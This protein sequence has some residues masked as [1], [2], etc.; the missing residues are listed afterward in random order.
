MNADDNHSSDSA[1]PF[2]RH[3][4]STWWKTADSKVLMRCSVM[5]CG[6]FRVKPFLFDSYVTH[7][8]GIAGGTIK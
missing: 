1:Y 2:G 5:H 4:R 6:V 7:S 3:C 8:T